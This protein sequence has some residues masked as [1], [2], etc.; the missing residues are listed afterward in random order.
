MVIIAIHQQLKLMSMNRNIISFL[1]LTVFVL[2]ISS[3][4]KMERPKLADDYPTDD[5]QVTI[6]GPL[7]FYAG[8]NATNGPSPRWNAADSISGNPALL[9]PSSYTPGATGNALK[10]TDNAAVLYLN[11]NDF[12]TATSFSISFW[13]K[14]TAQ[15]GRTEFMFSLVK[16]SYS[17]HN[18]MIFL[19]VENQTATNATMKLG[20]M[21]Q[22]LEGTFN[23]PMFDGNWHHIV[24]AYDQTTSKMKYYFDGAEVTGL[25]ATQ[26][27]V[28]NGSNPRGA[29]DFSGVTNLILGGWNKHVRLPGPPDDWIKSYAGSLDQF[30]LYNKALTSTEVQ[31]LFTSKM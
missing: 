12:K 21:D 6:P 10:G 28:K 19:L 25:T 1:S 2:V 15:V 22:W 16:P 24:Y 4:Q 5:N 14:N 7:R 9:F 3:C 13:M 11:A 8:F 23:K 27:D 30:R 29:V 17:W 20:V 18:S 31:A 26:T